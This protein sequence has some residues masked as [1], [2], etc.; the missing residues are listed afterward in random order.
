MRS[1]T[2]LEYVLLGRPYHSSFPRFFSACFC[3]LRHLKLKLFKLRSFTDLRN[4]MCRLENLQKLELISGSVSARGT[5]EFPPVDA[6]RLRD[7]TIEGMSKLHKSV[8][9]GGQ[10]DPGLR[11]A[12]SILRKVGPSLTSLDFRPWLS[13]S[14]RHLGALAC[15]TR[16]VTLELMLHANAIESWQGLVAAFSEI[17][18]NCTSPAIHTIRAQILMEPQHH[19][20]HAA[21]SDSE[22]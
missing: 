19:I 4:I 22:F 3:A 14:W 21:H 5:S 6:P 17:L 7:V 18:S 15:C 11:S 16:L 13:D 12:K 2:C 20:P 1:L 10:R 9:F 8:S